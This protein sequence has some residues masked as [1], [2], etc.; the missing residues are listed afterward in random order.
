MR[1]DKQGRLVEAIDETDPNDPTTIRTK[2]YDGTQ[3]VESTDGDVTVTFGYDAA[4]RQ[5]MRTVEPG[6]GDTYTMER[7]YTIQ[8]NPKAVIY[9]DGTRVEYDYGDHGSPVTASGFVEDVT[10]DAHERPTELTFAGDA[11]CSYEYDRIEQ[12]MTKAALRDGSGSALR[13]LTYEYD[14]RKNITAITDEFPSETLH[15]RFEYDRLLR[16]TA[17]ERRAGGPGGAPDTRNEYAY[18][19]TGDLTRNDESMVGP[20]KYTDPAHGGRLTEVTPTGESTAVSLSYDDTGR[21]TSYGDLKSLEYDIWDRLIEVET[22]DGR[23]VRF[24][25]DADGNRVEKTIDTGDGTRTTTYVGSR[26]EDR[27]DGERLS[28]KL[29][30]LTVGVKEI[31]EGDEDARTLHILTDHLGSLVAAC[32]DTGSIVHQQVYSPYGQ[33]MRSGSDHSRYLGLDA[34]QDIGIAQFGDRYYVPE[35]GRFLTPDWFILENPQPALRHP[36][37]LNVY[38]YAV[39]NPVRFKDPSGKFAFLA[40]VG[41]GAAVGFAAG[42]IGGTVYGLTQGENLGQSMLRGLEAGLLGVAGGALGAATGGAV[43]GLLGFSATAGAAIGGAFGALNGYI[44]GAKQNYRWSDGSGFAAFLSDSTWGLPGTA[45]GVMVHFVNWTLYGGGN[46][47]EEASHRS[48]HH[49]YDGGFAIKSDYAFTQG[50]VISNLQGDRGDL[51]RHEQLHVTQSRV[52]G[53]IF[54]GTYAAWLIAGGVVGF[55]IG[56]FTG[57]EDLGE[58]IEDVAYFDNPWETWAYQQ[59]GPSDNVGGRLSWNNG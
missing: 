12:D 2:T 4:G 46:Y 42:F 19:P 43:F 37:G 34:D 3:L 55:S 7:E 10:Y 57:N 33:S 54:Q 52:F 1:Y 35:L 15:R 24:E 44:S 38:S 8:G 56:I 30:D 14:D 18:T 17:A 47:S 21:V 48:N 16:L 11:S 6:T 40:A 41:I 50:N 36:Q 13:S 45:L 28:V 22:D 23:I 20:M 53:P 26:Y 39:N 29:G 32:D 25:Y 59:E 9:P 5:A 27:P 58:D 51:Y 49:V 31:P